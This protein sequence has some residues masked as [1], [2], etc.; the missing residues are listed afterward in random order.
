MLG[1]LSVPEFVCVM[2]CKICASFESRNAHGMHT[3][4]LK[5]TAILDSPYIYIFFQN[6]FLQTLH[7]HDE[8][9]LE[10]E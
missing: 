10:T 4:T 7:V 1:N 2:R 3:C 9:S 6:L 8:E 5:E